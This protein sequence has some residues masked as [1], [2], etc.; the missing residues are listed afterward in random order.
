MPDR[1]YYAT[2]YP[3]RFRDHFFAHYGTIILLVSSIVVS[4]VILFGPYIPGYESYL[5]LA[6]GTD[7][8][9]SRAGQAVTVIAGSLLV[10][11]GYFIP[12]KMHTEFLDRHWRYLSLGFWLMGTGWLS[13]LVTI[14]IVD[15][16]S[17]IPVIISCTGLAFSI[18]GFFITRN[19]RRSVRQTVKKYITFLN[20]EE[21][22]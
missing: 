16:M 12:I 22:V 14:F 9:L 15:P 3:P 21:G 8:L 6:D 1:Q 13:H 4:L 20:R 2:R 11:R 18:F 19:I 5:P 17:L 7:R 10:M